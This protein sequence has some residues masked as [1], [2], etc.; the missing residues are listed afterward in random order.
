MDWN[1]FNTHGDSCN[2]AFEI[3]CNIIF[4]D[5]CEAEYGK[6]LKYFSFINGNGGDGGIEAY[7]LLD[8]GDIIAIQTK[9]FPNLL[10][11]EQF[12]QIE[13]SFKT[14]IGIRPNICRYIVCVP[15]NL[16]SKKK[17]SNDRIAKNTEE[18]KW[19]KLV[20]DLKK[21]YSGV[22]IELWGETELEKKLSNKRLKGCYGYWFENKFDLRQNILLSYDK[23]IKTWAKANYIPD[24][25]SIGYV[26]DNLEKFSG[27]YPI[28][29]KRYN[30]IKESLSILYKLRKLYEEIQNLSIIEQ[31]T[32]F[33]YNI[34]KDIDN[35]NLW[36]DRFEKVIVQVSEGVD[37]KEDYLDEYFELYC[38]ERDFK[39]LSLYYRFYNHFINIIKTMN[40][41]EDMINECINHLVNTYDNRI[42]F[43]G[44]PG[45][46]KTAGIVSEV[47]NFIKEKSHLPILVRAKEFCGN[48]NWLDILTSTLNLPKTMS[49][50]ELLQMLENA[51]LFWNKSREE[52]SEINIQPKCLICVDGIDESESH[53]YWIDRIKEASAYEKNFKNVKFVFLSRP[54]V[55]HISY[56]IKNKN[57]GG[58][59]H[60]V[61]HIPVWGD[62]P[63]E[64]IFDQYIEYYKINL[65]TNRWIKNMLRTPLALK[66]FCNIYEGK[67]ITNLSKNSIIITSLFDE[68]IK[69]L[70]NKYNMLKNQ[71]Y[72][73]NFVRNT[74][75]NI[76]TM[77]V[78]N[79]ELTHDDIYNSCKDWEKIYLDD[80]IDFLI[81]EGFLCVN[82]NKSVEFGTVET[83]YTWGIQQALEY[84]IAMKLYGMIKKN[85]NIKKSYSEGINKMLAIILL[86]EEGKL[87]SDYEG[88]DF[89]ENLNFDYISYALV[90]SSINAAVKYKLYVKK[91]MQ[92][93]P[94]KFREVLNKI[95][96]PVS[97]MPEHPLGSSLLDEFL[98]HF[99]KP[100][101]RDV[102]WSVPT[103]IKLDS[104]D[105]IYGYSDFSLYYNKY[106]ICIGDLELELDA[107]YQGQPLIFV[108][109]LSSLNNS[110][111]YK[112]RIKLTKWA[113]NNQLGFFNLFKYCSD[114]ND[115]QIIEDLFSIAYG[116]S[117]SFDVENEYLVT[118]TDW[119][120]QN[121]FTNNG[122]I[123]YENVVIRYYCS[124]IVKIAI[125]KKLYDESL[126]L[127]ITPPYTYDAKLMPM[128]KEAVDSTRDMGYKTI[129]YDLAR[130]VLCEHFD[131]F[132]LSVNKN[133]EKSKNVDNMLEAYKA[134]Y[135][136]DSIESDGLII[137]IAYQ[138][139]LDQ[140][141][142]NDIN[143]TNKKFSIEKLDSSITNTYIYGTHG[144]QSNV[145]TICEKYVWCARHR[146]DAILANRF[147]RGY[148]SDVEMI[149]DYLI[150][151]NFVNTYQDS[152]NEDIVYEDQYINVDKIADLNNNEF[153]KKSIEEWVLDKKTPNFSTWL[154]YNENNEILYANMYRINEESGVR[155]IICISSGVTKKNEFKNFVKQL[156]CYW[157]TRREFVDVVNFCSSQ[158]CHCYCSPQEICTVRS[159]KE[160]E[161]DIVIETEK[162]KTTVHK[163]VGECTI[164]KN[165]DSEI[166]LCLPS[167][168]TRDLLEITY[169]DGC[170]YLDKKKSIMSK[171]VMNKVNSDS[172]QNYLIAKKK[173]L[174]ES[175]KR[176]DYK[177]F[178][179][180]KVY[181]S[182]SPKA[183]EFFDREII[184]DSKN[185][186]MVW[187]EDDCY[188]SII[189]EDVMPPQKT[190]KEYKDILHK[191]KYHSE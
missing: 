27:N 139:L 191:Y 1:K 23:A 20:E 85:V 151:D 83:T 148:Y 70:E 116:V 45:T 113:I 88:F 86:E 178:W 160:I 167:K 32:L 22:S 64:K 184:Y 81:T 26:H 80:I 89:G 96:L 57:S 183:Y 87:L 60:C 119:I 39:N 107:K 149:S 106:S 53:Y 91:L 78:E 175:L 84:L 5:W 25:Y 111:R 170:C 182:P 18:D 115:E 109:A 132:L 54:N 97:V 127:K 19:L 173:V 101:I 47:N 150:L 120:M 49:D 137:A 92:Q 153:I 186:Y 177:L 126:Y 11:S 99:N 43:L 37:I 40:E 41:A 67:K 189:L 93:S 58:L 124:S 90:N 157:D 30:K 171:Y 65:G 108:W 121:V 146:I 10:K 152:I 181:R 12:E 134:K 161:C 169:G 141:W 63:V 61:R 42:I 156:N 73:R 13:K 104:T 51:A 71:K 74:L 135:N 122:L 24:L 102:W 118:F 48:D 129:H 17:V 56:F 131:L 185:T 123:K 94:K 14:A 133:D 79:K 75:V 82:Q 145:M 143:I 34:K 179:L 52:K 164:S 59:S 16:T 95:I 190:M 130:Y 176:K 62:I 103:D 128:Y 142:K 140:G 117:L 154:N 6:C 125:L 38:R 138:Y 33:E 100:V 76:A 7:G 55:F 136:L 155:E 2:H 36:I 28:V 159:D 68:K 114:I 35:L 9:W 31:E 4:K 168:L 162:Y 163:L 50:T 77:F 3:M 166:N 46:G 165:F 8:T 21:D 105:F 174:S 66:L 29:Q 147:P 144:A 180:F 112:L 188:K 72:N 110:E 15:R 187:L 98:R 69:M 158:Q 172:Y 44:Q